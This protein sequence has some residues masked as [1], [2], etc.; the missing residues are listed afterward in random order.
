MID[1]PLVLTLKQNNSN[2]VYCLNDDAQKAGLHR[3]MPYADARAFCPNLQSHPADPVNDQ[4]F[5]HILR[6]W[7]TRYCPWVGLDGSDGLVLDVTGS[8]HLFGSEEVMLADMQMRL[9]RAGVSARLSIADTRGAAWAL[10]HYANGNN[11]AL[12]SLPVAAL[13]LPDDIIVSLARLGVRR[14]ADLIAIPRATLTR[15][16][17]REVLMRVD[18]ALGHQVEN[19]TPLSN[20]PH[21]GVR[22][23]FPDPIGLERDVIAATG[24][25]LD[26][27]CPK[28]ENQEA[29]ART[30]VLTVYRVDQDH[31]QV[32]LRLASPLRDPRRILSLFQR[33]IGAVK[34]GYGI[35]KI[36]LEAV[37]V[38]PLPARQTN[39]VQNSDKGEL[40]DLISRIGTRIGIENIHRFLPADSHIP[41]RSFNIALAAYSLPSEPWVCL[42]PRPIVLFPP[43]QIVANGA[44]PPQKFQWRG[45]QLTTGKATGPE[46]IAP[47]WW[48]DDENWRSGVRDYWRVETREGWRLWLFYTPQKP[49][50]FVQGQFA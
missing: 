2:R 48:L 27:L 47:E 7:A 35:D 14:I 50:W 34:A 32:E 9:D 26:K 10:T 5:L 37:Q 1:G 29:G 17:G 31:Q 21:Y 42:Y 39:H 4:A 45:M 13:R 49:A 23:S 24:R 41:E 19:I 15:R 6:R 30:L 43:E 38:E 25:L 18:Q 12:E 40:D 20:P 3:G 46:R 22:I 44:R 36:R 28:L 8:T 33:G 11:I 16:F